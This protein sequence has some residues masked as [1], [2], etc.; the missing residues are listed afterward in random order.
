MDGVAIKDHS[1]LSPKYVKNIID[2]NNQ[3]IGLMK[4]LL[5][6]NKTTPY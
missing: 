2:I 5:L 4:L 3:A 6:S 1:L